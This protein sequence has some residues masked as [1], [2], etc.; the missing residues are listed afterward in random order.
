MYEHVHNLGVYNEYSLYIDDI[1]KFCCLP[2]GVSTIQCDFY[3]WEVFSQNK[4][5]I[6]K[7][8]LFIPKDIM[9]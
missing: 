2:I 3:P 4:F 7:D 5:I 6:N 8:S 1:K 9:S